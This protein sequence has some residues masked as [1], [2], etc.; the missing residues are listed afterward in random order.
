MRELVSAFHPIVPG[1]IRVPQA[2]GSRCGSPVRGECGPRIRKT[3]PIVAAR[4]VLTAN[5]FQSHWESARSHFAAANQAR[6]WLAPDRGRMG[7]LLCWRYCPDTPPLVKESQV[8][9]GEWLHYEA[10]PCAFRDRPGTA[11][12]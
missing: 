9:R 4:S 6:G 1:N 11:D 8:G 7:Y 3:P 5:T 12:H 10:V 2:S